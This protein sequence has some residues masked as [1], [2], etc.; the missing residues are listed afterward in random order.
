[1]CPRADRIAQDA[2]RP[3]EAPLH[4]AAAAAAER[5]RETKE[6]LL[7]AAERLFAER[8][9]IAGTSVSAANY[10]FGSK[11][12][13]LRETLRRRVDPANARRIARLDALEHAAAGRPLTL[14]EILGAFLIPLFEERAERADAARNVR[15][16]AARLYAERPA[17]VAAL[18]RELFGPVT[19]RFV[20][21]LARALPE[22]TP[23][24]VGLGLQLVVGVMVHV[25][26]GNLADAPSLAAVDAAGEAL[27]DQAVLRQMLSFVAAGLRARPGETA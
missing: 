1:V 12:E 27:S 9:F 11:E 25:M 13:L 15:F 7:D 17:L 2:G 19:D 14:E 26:S 8:G 18:K 22:R 21:A 10:H 3:R 24:E 16:V 4:P 20:P 23:E 5:G 6:R